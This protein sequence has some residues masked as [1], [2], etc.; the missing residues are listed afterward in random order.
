ML[1]PAPET[2]T[3]AAEWGAITGTLADQT[4]LDTALGAKANTAALSS[5]APLASP[6]L[7]G[8]PTVPTQA[9]GNDSTRAASTA[10]VATAIAARKYAETIGDGILSSF[11]VTHNLDTTDIT[12]ITFDIPTGQGPVGLYPTILDADSVLMEAIS[13]P[14]INQ[15]RVVIH[16]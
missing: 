12:V 2:S 1:K 9:A 14:D 6:A 11:T 7:T 16:G 3:G 15:Y 8:N 5:Y 13:P 10:F 4:D